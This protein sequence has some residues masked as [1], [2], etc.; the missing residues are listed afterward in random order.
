MILFQRL[1][2]YIF[3]DTSVNWEG[4]DIALIDLE[5]SKLSQ[6]PLYSWARFEFSSVCAA[7]N[8]GVPNY[9][10]QARLT[11]TDQSQFVSFPILPSTTS[12]KISCRFTQFATYLL[13]NEEFSWTISTDKLR[14][15]ALGT[16]FDNVSLEK[17]VTFK[18]FNN[19]PGVTISNFSLPS[20]DVDGGI[21]IETD[22]SIPSPS[23][24]YLSAS[25]QP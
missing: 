10:T 7:A 3:T 2:I 22:V 6:W 18:A 1:Y 4:H 20:D 13:H 19:L 15:T 17:T 9:E 21:H 14:L 12:T 24:E 8:D 11:I 5:P 16:I 23:R 25:S